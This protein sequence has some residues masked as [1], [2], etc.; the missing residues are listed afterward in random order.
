[1]L[2]YESSRVSLASQFKVKLLAELGWADLSLLLFNHFWTDNRSAHS[3]LL[4]CQILS[5]SF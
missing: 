4:T 2:N 1:M 5:P 3:S